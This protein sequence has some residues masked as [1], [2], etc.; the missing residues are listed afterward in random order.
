MDIVGEQFHNY[1]SERSAS[2]LVQQYDSHAMYC[3]G[4]SG[5]VLNKVYNHYLKVRI[6]IGKGCS[7]VVDIEFFLSYLISQ[8]AL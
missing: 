5:S 4:Y 6:I 3:T 8:W 7:S 1:A 2:L